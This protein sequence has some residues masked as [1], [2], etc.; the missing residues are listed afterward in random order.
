MTGV[1]LIVGILFM[2]WALSSWVTVF[3]D[4][5]IVRNQLL[6]PKPVRRRKVARM[7]PVKY[8][9]VIKPSRPERRKS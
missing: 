5:A 4:A 1:V 9:S 6:K 8:T 2:V 3:E 7:V